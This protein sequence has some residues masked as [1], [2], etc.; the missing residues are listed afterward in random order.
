M[1]R[2]SYP[3]MV[4]FIPLRS[5]MKFALVLFLSYFLDILCILTSYCDTDF[6]FGHINI[7]CDISSS[8]GL[9]LQSLIKVYVFLLAGLKL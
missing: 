3:L 5:V 9:L 6:E 2:M 7:M 1:L 8:Y 4:F